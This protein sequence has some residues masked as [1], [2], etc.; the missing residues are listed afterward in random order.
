MLGKQGW[1]L[2]SNPDSLCARVLK[3]KYFPQGDFM[4]AGK[5]KNASHTW[6]AILA[7]RHVLEM[8]L[9][10]RIGDGSST[11]IW[12]DRWIPNAIGNKPVCKKDGATA[13]TVADLLNV[14]GILWNEEALHQNLL[15]FDAEAVRQ[16]PLGRV[17]QDFW[18]WSRE[19]HGLYSVKS[20]YHLLAETEL[21]SRSYTTGASSLSVADK[22]PRWL[23]LWRQR[24]PQ[25]CECF[26][27][28]LCTI[29]C[30]V[31]QIFTGDML[32]Q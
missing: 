20:A 6:R 3:G 15:P 11:N 24:V 7:G 16:I 10:K 32:I 27:G 30:H 2:M 4:S 17:Q 23:K 25:R 1:R 12:Q 21:Q 5:K 26:G 9:I 18:A 19:K 29:T 22:D 28:G 8:G 31:G 13:S 14:D